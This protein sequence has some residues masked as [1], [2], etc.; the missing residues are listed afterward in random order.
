VIKVDPNTVVID[1]SPK[2]IAIEK[3]ITRDYKSVGDPMIDSILIQL[4]V[5]GR[6]NYQSMN[7]PYMTRCYEGILKY[8]EFLNVKKLGDEKKGDELDLGAIIDE[9][10]S[11]KPKE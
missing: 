11:K 4:L 1:K 6:V 10:K 7:V 3:E 5:L 8:S 9:L 2:L